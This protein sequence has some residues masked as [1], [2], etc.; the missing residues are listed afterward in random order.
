MTIDELLSGDELLTI[1]EEDT[2]QKET[3]FRDLV[4]GLLDCSTAMLFFLPVF[5][6]RSEGVV[7]GV[8][9]PALTGIAPYLKYAYFAAVIAMMVCG[10]LMLV[11]QVSRRS[12]RGSVRHKLSIA[13]NAAGALLFIVS[14][15]PYA[16]VVLFLFLTIKALLQMKW[17]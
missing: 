17:Q 2:R 5:G 1:A 11:L 3:K 4:Y 16:A 9:L 8:S 12:F 15:Q 6:Q 13:L 7:H 14:L 10:L